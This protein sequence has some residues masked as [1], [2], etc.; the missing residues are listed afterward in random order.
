[1]KRGTTS[2]C[3]NWLTVIPDSDS[4]QDT[5]SLIHNTHPTTSHCVMIVVLLF[6][7]G[8]NTHSVWKS[9]IQLPQIK[10]FRAPHHLPTEL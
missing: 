1:M 5:P 4:D 7:P 3:T 9:D 8:I 6:A 10:L 2:K